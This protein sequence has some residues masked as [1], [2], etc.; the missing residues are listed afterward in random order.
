M[1]VCQASVEALR[2]I[3]REENALQT[4]QVLRPE[5]TQ[6]ENRMQQHSLKY[7]VAAGLDRYCERTVATEVRRQMMVTAIA[8]K[9]YH[10]RNGKFPSQLS[11]LVPAFLPALPVDLIDGQPLRYRL[12]DEQHFLLY[13]IGLDGKDDGGDPAEGPDE[14]NL[15]GKNTG[16]DW[17]YPEPATAEEI[18]AEQA[19]NLEKATGESRPRPRRA[20]AT[21]PATTTNATTA[22]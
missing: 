13:S 18:S 4:L 6:W 16:R 1:H 11:Q 5:I 14:F 19:K 7:P 8:L 12:K 21:P 15:D 3:R 17:V 10:L 2:K 9:R 20:R 22:P